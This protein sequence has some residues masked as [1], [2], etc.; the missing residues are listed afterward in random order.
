ME[1]LCSAGGN[2]KWRNC[3]GKCMAAPQTHRDRATLWSSNALLD[4]DPK[5]LKAETQSD[6]SPRCSYGNGGVRITQLSVKRTS[7]SL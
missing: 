4:M 3:R 2:V 1:A 7:P 6:A 5:E